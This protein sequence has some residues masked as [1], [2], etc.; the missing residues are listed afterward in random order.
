MNDKNKKLYVGI[1]TYR[2][3]KPEP[4]DE[5]EYENRLRKDLAEDRDKKGALKE[6]VALYGNARRYEEAERCL[7]E[8]FIIASNLEDRAHYHLSR[9]QIMEGKR[10]FRA[11]LNEYNAAI[12]MQPANKAVWYLLHNNI[13]F[14]LIQLGEYRQAERWLQI[15][16]DIDPKMPNAYKNLGICVQRLGRYVEAARCFIA[17]IHAYPMDDRSLEHLEELLSAHPEIKEDD[18][19]IEDELKRC[20]AEVAT[21]CR[22]EPK[23]R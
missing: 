18:P 22:P 7:D 17:G 11:A 3:G 12:P 1:V 14:S 15:A 13:G 4:M 20:R 19:T 23:G 16:Q 21:A 8:L 6:L 2:W 9:G 10:D 5:V